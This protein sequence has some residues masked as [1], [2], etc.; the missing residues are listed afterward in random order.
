MCDEACLELG[1]DPVPRS[2]VVY[3]LQSIVSNTIK[4]KNSLPMIKRELLSQSQV[5]YIEDIIVTRDT[6]NLGISRKEEVQEI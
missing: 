2:T 3:C 6:V 1:D 5:N 4:Y